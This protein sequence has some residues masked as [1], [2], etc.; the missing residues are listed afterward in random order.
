[1][2]VT[3]YFDHW[4][5]M[6]NPF[7]AEEA[8]NDPVFARIEGGPTAHPDFEKIIGDLSR[9]CSAI[10]FGEKG[11]GKTAIRM[12]IASRTEKYNTANPQ[13]KLLLVLYDDLNQ[14]LDRFCGATTSFRRH[15]KSSAAAGA[16]DTLK[17]LK[18]LLLID[19][20]D[21]LLCAAV[22]PFV[23]RAISESAAARDLRRAPAGTK[24]D[25]QLLAALYD[26]PED[27]DRRAA[28][29][30]RRIATPW[31]LHRLLWRGLALS[32]WLLPALVAA[33][34][35][36][37]PNE[38]ISPT[39][40]LSSFYAALAVWVLLLLK[41]FL[42]DRWLIAATS[43]R[44]AR[45]MKGV[46]RS[47]ETI[48]GALEFLPPEDRQ[49]STLPIDAS[50]DKRYAMLERLRRVAAVLGYTG[51]LV[52]MDRVDEPTLVSGDP[53]R[54]R[55]VVW[56]LLNNKF[57]QQ[58]GIGVKLLLPIELR[59]ELF[60]E[61]SAFFQ[62]AR[63]DKQNLIERLVWSGPTLYDLCN[64]RLAACRSAG[65]PAITLL[66]LF[67]EDVTRQEL[68]DALDQMRQPRDAFKMLYQ[69]VQEH[70]STVIDNQS[71]WRIPR[72]LLET[73]RKQQADRVQML[74]RGVR[75]A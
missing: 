48:A 53:D 47:A 16:G 25:L 11:S 22:P 32:G 72:L 24:R 54:M 4:S 38:Y 42:L 29:L 45:K 12:Q 46:G 70:C 18:K 28:A 5:I 66:D 49:P 59:H 43:R 58:E 74:Y 15:G 67:A 55:A 26:K 8:R 75:P 34:A 3:T 57:L 60:R 62:E 35:F 19:H 10:V 68:V 44:L 73:V 71:A 23:D 50:D 21:G 40:K 41:W 36:Y 9:P 33:G 63:L 17:S 64:A 61:S 39:I 13:R 2:N 30:R 51:V 20:I 69:C 37:F 6:E 56:P 27:A 14:F 65:A 1:M 7:R 31:N 52:I